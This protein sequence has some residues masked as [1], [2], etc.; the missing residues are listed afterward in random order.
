MPTRFTSA[1]HLGPPRRFHAHDYQAFADS[2]SASGCNSAL[3][4][5]KRE[6]E[7]NAYHFS[8]FYSLKGNEPLNLGYCGLGKPCE[9]RTGMAPVAIDNTINQLL[10]DPQNHPQKGKTKPS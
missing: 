4:L 2:C 8:V 7:I 9:F 5:T 10:D 1:S 6:S 3:N